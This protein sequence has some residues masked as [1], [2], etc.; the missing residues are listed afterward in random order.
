MYTA[1]QIQ[2]ILDEA[3]VAAEKASNDLYNQYGTDGKGCCGFAWVNI[4]MLDGQKIKGNTKVGRTLKKLGIK[5]DWTRAFSVWNPSN[6]GGQNV[7][8]KE[9]GARAYAAVLNKYG[10]AAHAGSRLD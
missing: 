6:Y 5:Q 4:Y 8:I 1:N 7:D 10:F 3:S 2:V 9:V